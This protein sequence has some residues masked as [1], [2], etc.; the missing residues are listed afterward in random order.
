MDFVA[1]K[2]SVANQSDYEYRLSGF[3]RPARGKVTV[4]LEG[5]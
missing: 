3:A 5:D 4:G 2:E 1:G